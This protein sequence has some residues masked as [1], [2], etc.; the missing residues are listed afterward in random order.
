[1]TG[2][3]RINFKLA[4]ISLARIEILPAPFAEEG[5]REDF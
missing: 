1:V 3:V 4:E 2:K 5:G